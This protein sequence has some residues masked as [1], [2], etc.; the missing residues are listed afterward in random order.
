[1]KLI[2]SRIEINNAYHAIEEMR[3][4]KS[5]DEFEK[6]WKGFLNYLEKSWNKAERECQVFRN[7]FEPWQ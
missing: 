5:L 6:H 2:N 7:K 1:M 3:L 4:S